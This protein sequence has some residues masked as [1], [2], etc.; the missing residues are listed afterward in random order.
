M[1]S[2]HEP[3]IMSSWGLFLIE[4]LK[5]AHLVSELFIKIKA[6]YPEVTGLCFLCLE[7]G[8]RMRIIFSLMGQVP[9]MKIFIL[10]SSIVSNQ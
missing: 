7:A 9:I 6:V 1:L 10:N 5:A 3:G 4:G 2:Y 8:C